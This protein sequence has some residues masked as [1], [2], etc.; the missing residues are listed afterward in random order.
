M[1]ARKRFKRWLK[2]AGIRA[3]K[4][5]SQAALGIIGTSVVIAD[6][7]WL[8]VVSATL[9]AMI[10]SLLMS[11]AGLPEIDKENDLYG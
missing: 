2:R 8:M 3:L 4:T 9:V 11:T 1:T 7:D 10:V 6:I 5:G